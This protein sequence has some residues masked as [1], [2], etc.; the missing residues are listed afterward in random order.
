MNKFIINTETYSVA[1]QIAMLLNNY[2]NLET[3]HTPN[4]ILGNGVSYIIEFGGVN[5]KHIDGNRKI[6]GMVGLQV[7]SQQ[8]NLVKHLCVHKNYRHFGI[9]TSLLK[10]AIILNNANILQMNVRSDNWPSLYLAEKLGF[11]YN[12]HI[13]KNGYFILKLRRQQCH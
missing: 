4:T 10:Q 2:N 5:E 8:I 6:V 1:S 9:A 13:S 11:L 12:N 7:I 3:K